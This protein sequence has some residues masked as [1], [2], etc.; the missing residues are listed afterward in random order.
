MKFVLASLCLLL[1]LNAQAQSNVPAH[2]SL[3]IFDSTWQEWRTINIWL[4]PSYSTTSEFYPVLYMLDG[5][6]EE[7]FVHMAQS[8]E[9]LVA[10]KK[11]PPYILVGI[12]NTQRRRDLTG[13]TNV[14]KDKTIAPHVGE[15]AVF[16]N[17]L[18]NH[19]ITTI[20][21]NYRVTDYK[22]II[23]ESVAG[24]FVIETFLQSPS[25][26]NFYIAFDPS[27]WWNKHQLVKDSEQYLRQLPNAPVKLWMAASNTKDIYK[28]TDEFVKSINQ[29]GLKQLQWHYTFEKNEK[30][31]TIFK[32]TKEKALIW[33]LNAFEL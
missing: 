10:D 31:A 1:C 16:R 12:Q 17:W 29:S 32:A 23:G 28:H 26:F 14:T 20:S 22:G 13:P 8:M 30:H 2:Q 4:P 24:L 11:I 9:T 21:T 15:S 18:Q 7:D 6:L 19:V 27:L 25:L 33:S 5:G 3:Q